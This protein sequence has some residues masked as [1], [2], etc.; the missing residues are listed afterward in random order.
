[1]T[2]KRNWLRRAAAVVFSIA[3]LGGG[4][5]VKAPAAA[6]GKQ[7]QQTKT[8][9]ITAEDKKDFRELTEEYDPATDEQSEEVLEEAE[10]FTAELT[11]QEVKELRRDDRVDLIE[12]DICVQGSGKKTQQKKAGRSGRKE[13][14]EPE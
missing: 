12:E 1:M 13:T 7:G 11:R 8:Y 5:H 14:E 3:L 9:I 6:Q 4:I 10:T 2:G